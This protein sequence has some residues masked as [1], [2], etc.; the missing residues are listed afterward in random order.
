M[1]THH[2]FALLFGITLGLLLLGFGI[3]QVLPAMAAGASSFY[4]DPAGDDAA[5]CDAPAAACKTIAAA[6]A[7][8]NAGDTIY[9]AAGTYTENVTVPKP[10]TFVGAGAGTTSV[11]GGGSGRVFNIT[12]A[13]VTLEA[14]TLPPGTVLT[15]MPARLRAA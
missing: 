7:K 13:V 8:A 15:T 12:G 6:I 5:A 3:L 11:D 10:L 4:V 1:K 14:L 2:K 9:L